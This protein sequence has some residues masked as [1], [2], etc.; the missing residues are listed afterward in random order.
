MFFQPI[1]LLQHVRVRKAWLD[2]VRHGWMTP[3]TAG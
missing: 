1:Q 3:D 2:D